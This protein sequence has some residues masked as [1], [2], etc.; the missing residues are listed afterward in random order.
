MSENY[1]DI[2]GIDK[3]ASEDDIKKAFRKLALKTHPDKNNGDD[4]EFKKINNAYEILSDPIK[5]ED[6][7]NS[8]NN[9][10]PNFHTNLNEHFSFNNLFNTVFNHIH[11]PFNN[12]SN[13]ILY[14]IYVSLKDIHEGTTKNLKLSINKKCFNCNIICNKC[15]G[16]GFI[17]QIQQNFIFQQQIKIPCNS[18]N[19][20]GTISN[21]N[22]ECHLCNGKLIINNEE[23]LTINIPKCTEHGHRIIF[24]NLG[25]QPTKVHDISGD[26]I[27]EIN[28]KNDDIFNRNQNNLIYKTN[29]TLAESIVGKNITIPHYD[30][31]IN[32]NTN[33]FG[34][35][36]P[37]KTYILKEK[38]LGNI[39]DL[40]IKFE[41]IY[42][43]KQIEQSN[44]EV[45]SELFKNIGI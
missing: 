17:T 36:D 33:I 31:D 44:R 18:C 9:P 8:L 25:E 2:L 5:K 22:K 20:N 10:F 40:L 37:N 27:I 28:I 35:I 19:S 41:I 24:H 23:N 4:N 11:N 13:D 42:P 29:L 3:N 16:L 34:I 45:L 38:G 43:E 39:G 30:G 14:K 12:K 26:L 1:Y 7:D 15:N 32:I 21:I 6:Y